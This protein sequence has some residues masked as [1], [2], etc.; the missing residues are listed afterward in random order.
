MDKNKDRWKSINSSFKQLKSSLKNKLDIRYIRVKGIDGNSMNKNEDV[1]KIL[2]LKPS[3]IGHKFI[4]QELSYHW[5]YDGSI[6]KSFPGL[7]L[8]GHYGT[9]G[10]ILSNLKT[11]DLILE[12]YPRYEWYIILEDDAIINKKSMNKINQTILQ[13]NPMTQVVVIDD[14]GKGG[15]AGI[16]YRKDVIKK[17]IKHMHPLSMFSIKNES[18]ISGRANLW[19]W[20][21]WSFLDYFKI[22]Y[23]V[24]PIIANDKFPSTIDVK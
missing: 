2:S 18:K 12:K 24:I 11:F 1:Q 22:K 13:I 21:L 14:R 15:T 7:S 19:D 8:N 9:K 10:I 23:E 6:E 3:L 20:K 5:I 16:I 4:F 17:A